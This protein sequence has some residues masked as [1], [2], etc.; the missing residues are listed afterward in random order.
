MSEQQQPSSEP[1]VISEEIIKLQRE[2][3]QLCAALRGL[4][5]LQAV[6]DRKLDTVLK[7]GIGADFAVL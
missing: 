6:M 1:R 4:V 7:G 3:A 2:V 5:Q